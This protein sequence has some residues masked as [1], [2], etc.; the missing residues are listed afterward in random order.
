MLPWFLSNPCRGYQLRCLISPRRLPV[1]S[2]SVDVARNVAEMTTSE[3][4]SLGAW[5]HRHFCRTNM[6]CASSWYGGARSLMIST[7]AIYN[8]S[9]L[10]PLQGPPHSSLLRSHSSSAAT[11][12]QVHPTIGLAFV[13]SGKGVQ[14]ACLAYP[15]DESEYL[16]G[17][18]I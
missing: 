12:S 5:H 7:V 10:R 15:K 2:P 14:H 11:V 3:D 16:A 9:P 13:N 4:K 6:R 17:F 8:V 18:K 1:T